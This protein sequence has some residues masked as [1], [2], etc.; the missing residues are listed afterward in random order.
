[1][2]KAIESTLATLTAFAALAGVLAR[3]RRGRMIMGFGQSIIQPEDGE[4]QITA[5]A[6]A[7]IGRQ[8]NDNRLSTPASTVASTK[9]GHKAKEGG[10]RK[11]AR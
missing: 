5:C 11:E 2:T 1:M 10:Q 7:P 3:I 4:R 6:K 8:P 9:R